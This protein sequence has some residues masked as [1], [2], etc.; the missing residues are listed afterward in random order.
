MNFY[1][2]AG[3]VAVYFNENDVLFESQGRNVT[4]GAVCKGDEMY[5]DKCGQMTTSRAYKESEKIAGV[6]CQGMYN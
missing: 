1:Y 5:L 3:A 2:M 6:L 4:D